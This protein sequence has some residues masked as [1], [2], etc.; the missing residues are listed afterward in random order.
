MFAPLDEY[1]QRIPLTVLDRW[2]QS[3]TLELPDAQ[4]YVRFHPAHYLR[5]LMRAGPAYQALVLCWKNGQRSPIHDHEGSSCAVKVLAGVATETLF[6]VAPNGMI[7]AT[8]SR[9][10]RAG[11]TTASQDADIHQMS[12]LQAGAAELITLHVYSPPLLSMH[13]YSLTTADVSRFFDPINDELVGG[14]GI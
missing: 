8:G 11:A 5:N 14:A 6:S 12:N 10:L 2:L 3:V 1:D 7:Y 9:A 4:S 13:V